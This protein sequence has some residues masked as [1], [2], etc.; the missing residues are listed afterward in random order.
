MTVIIL[1]NDRNSL[2]TKS[3]EFNMKGSYYIAH[4]HCKHMFNKPW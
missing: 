2:T 4:I 1:Y 3:V